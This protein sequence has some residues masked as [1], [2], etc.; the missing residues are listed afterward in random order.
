MP[1]AREASEAAKVSTTSTAAAHGSAARGSASTA[2]H[3]TS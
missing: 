1:A 3:D 2:C